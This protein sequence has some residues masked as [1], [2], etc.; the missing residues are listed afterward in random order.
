MQID[1]VSRF[2]LHV[3]SNY[4]NGYSS[5]HF[6]SLSNVHHSFSILERILTLMIIKEKSLKINKIHFKT[7]LNIF[8]SNLFLTLKI[9]NFENV[10]LTN[11]I[12]FSD[13]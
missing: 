6:F 10:S 7:H 12:H 2:L 13:I 1:H 8:V 4:E 11:V 5:K 3:Q 9:M